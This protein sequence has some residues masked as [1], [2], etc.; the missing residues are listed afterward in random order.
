MPRSSRRF[1]R[2]RPVAG[3]QRNRCGNRF[4]RSPDSFIDPLR[5]MRRIL[6]SW[7]S[8]NV[9]SYMAMMYLGLFA[10]VFGGAHEAQLSGMSPDKFAVATVILVIPAMVGSQL[11]FV[12]PHW[13]VYLREVQ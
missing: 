11:L 6:F 2:D 7:N 13:Y 4:R 10:G 5:T 3:S 9:Y 12:L 1:Y 8:F